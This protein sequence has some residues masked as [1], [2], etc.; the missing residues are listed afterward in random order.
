MQCYNATNSDMAFCIETLSCL[1]ILCSRRQNQHLKFV[2]IIWFHFVEFLTYF[3]FWKLK[4]LVKNPQICSGKANL[5]FWAFTVKVG[6]ISL[7][8]LV[9]NCWK[10]AFLANYLLA[11]TRSLPMIWIKYGG[12]SYRKKCGHPLLWLWWKDGCLI[13]LLE[14]VSNIPLRL[15]LYGVSN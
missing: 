12:C 7:L 1:C 5:I 3:R 15:L 13:K 10:F 8:G 11:D 2:R 14:W 9:I 4:F 6:L